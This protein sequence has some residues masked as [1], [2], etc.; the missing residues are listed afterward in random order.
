[1]QLFNPLFSEQTFLKKK[2]GE[3]IKKCNAFEADLNPFNENKVVNEELMKLVI[4][5]KT[6]ENCSLKIGTCIDC[7]S[8]R[9]REALMILR[10]YTPR[11]EDDKIERRQRR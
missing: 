10:Y 5:E 3:K 11:R 8:I 6:I 2:S 7:R 4:E 9:S 1:M